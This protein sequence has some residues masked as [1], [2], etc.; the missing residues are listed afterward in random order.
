MTISSLSHSTYF[1]I[2]LESPSFG[3]QLVLTFSTILLVLWNGDYFDNPAC[4]VRIGGYD[5]VYSYRNN[6]AIRLSAE[7]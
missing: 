6:T 2:N 1:S 4:V 7:C 5:C 3:N